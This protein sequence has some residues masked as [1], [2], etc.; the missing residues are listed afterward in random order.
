MKRNIY[1]A[2]FSND[3]L[4]VITKYG[5]GIEYN[6][7]CISSTLDP[8][9]VDKTVAAM[10]KE[11][12]ECGL[13]DADGE[14]IPEMA[15]VHGP[16]TEIC[17]QSI[18]H[19]AVDMAFVRL[20]QTY[21]ATRAL[22]IHRLVVH[23]GFIPLIY[24]KEWHVKQSI[25]FWKKFMQDKPDDF[26]IYI[27]NVLDDE[28]DSLIEIVNGIDDPR[29][30]LCLDIGHANVVTVPE[31]T[32]IDWIKKMGPKI[33]HF[34]LHNND[35]TGDQ[36]GPVMKGSMDINK[37]IKAIDEYCS[38]DVTFTVESRECDESIRWLLDNCK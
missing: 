10:K 21:E 12:V 13:A 30:K 22:G 18:D 31:Y 16:F 2:T 7:F 29:V 19:M 35:G 4:E 23:S 32:V 3:A 38:E 36:H 33:G 20:N 9:R 11:A 37:V 5:I 1:L 15:V 27:E 17:P 26:N 14:V 6:Q 25:K 28:P 34:H 24:F 8:E